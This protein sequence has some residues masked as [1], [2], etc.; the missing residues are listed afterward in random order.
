MKVMSIGGNSIRVCQNPTQCHPDDLARRSQCTNTE[1]TL[2]ELREDCPG[3]RV[4]ANVSSLRRCNWKLSYLEAYW[5][6]KKLRG[7]GYPRHNGE[8]YTEDGNAGDAAWGGGCSLATCDIMKTP[9][10]PSLSIDGDCAGTTPGQRPQTAEEHSRA[11]TRRVL[12][13]T[14]RRRS[15]VECAPW[16]TKY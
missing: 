10:S 2:I 8:Y 4:S 12:E 13:H 14:V 15:P 1:K 11:I 3:N 7:V 16:W 6:R 5:G 9:F